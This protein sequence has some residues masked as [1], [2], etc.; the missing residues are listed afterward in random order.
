MARLSWALFVVTCLAAAQ[1][2]AVSKH[3]RIHLP[4]TVPAKSVHIVYY[5]EGPFGGSSSQVQP[6]EDALVYTL[7]MS[8]KETSATRMRAVIW[9][10]GCE[11]QTFDLDL[12]HSAQRDVDYNC[13]AQT[14]TLLTGRLQLS[15]ILRKEPHHIGISYE[16]SWVCRFF[17]IADCRVPVFPVDNVTLADEETFTVELPDF[18][19]VPEG[20]SQDIVVADSSFLLFLLDSKM[21]PLMELQPDSEEVTAPDRNLK[22]LSTYP[23]ALSFSPFATL[24]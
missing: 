14:S 22:V 4:S 2:L 18:N 5:L 15:S 10:R 7:P 17:G 21:T 19:H 20:G 12:L 13:L 6:R 16:A 1:H 8:T 24:H 9:T 11:V 23:P 3:I